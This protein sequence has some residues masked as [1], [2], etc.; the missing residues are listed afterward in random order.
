MKPSVRIIKQVESINPQAILLDGYDEC[1]LGICNTATSTVFAYSEKKIIQKL[2]LEGMSE[3]EAWEYYDG[4]I[5]N[6]CIGENFPV[7]IAENS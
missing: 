4:K 1:I 6:T 5:L 7:F 2:K 3:Q